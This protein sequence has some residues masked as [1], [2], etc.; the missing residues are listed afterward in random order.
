MP[1]IKP[2]IIADEL[3]RIRLAHRGRLKP[4]DVLKSATPK[5]SPI[6]AYFNWDDTKAAHKH[7]LEQAR[8]L[9]RVSVRVLPNSEGG[10]TK[11]SR[12]YSLRADRAEKTGYREIGEIMSNA[13][14]RATMLKESLEDLRAWETRH[15]RL[16]EL[17]PI[18]QA[19]KTVREKVAA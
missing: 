9:I 16:E 5:S 11:V 7:R 3:E 1:R 13:K 6:H 10:E 12:Y 14:L 15:R 2:A 19:A 4:E 8:E 18:R 17:E